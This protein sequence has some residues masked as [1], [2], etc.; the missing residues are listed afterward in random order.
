MMGT[1]APLSPSVILDA[2]LIEKWKSEKPKN[3]I[4]IELSARPP[5]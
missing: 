2:I 5:T 4:R 3:A 1:I